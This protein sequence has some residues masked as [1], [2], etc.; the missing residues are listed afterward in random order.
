M[1]AASEAFKFV[2]AP[3]DAILAQHVHVRVVTLYRASVVSRAWAALFGCPAAMARAVDSEAREVGWQPPPGFVAALREGAVR[4]AHELSRLG[5]R[6]R[7]LVTQA[8][9]EE[10]VWAAVRASSPESVP[11]RSLTT[12]VVVNESGLDCWVHGIEEGADGRGCIRWRE[13][14]MV[15][16]AN[17]SL[18]D[19]SRPRLLETVDAAGRPHV[20]LLVRVS[21]LSHAFAL[22]ASEGAAPFA[23]YQQR[24]AFLEMR[25][26]H[27]RQI[28]VHAL[29]ILEGLEIE[30]LVCVQRLPV[31]EDDP[32]RL[33]HF[34]AV[35]CVD[36]RPRNSVVEPGT[37]PT[38][39]GSY[40]RRFRSAPAPAKTYGFLADEFAGLSLPQ[41][42]A[43]WP[44]QARTIVNHVLG[45][46]DTSYSHS[47][48]C[49]IDLTHL[50]ARVEGQ[51][52]YEEIWFHQDNL[53]A[54]GRLHGQRRGP[55]LDA[56]AACQQPSPA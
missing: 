22:C 25:T 31:S 20:G 36:N 17:R 15:A 27:W 7:L 10:N 21:T 33:P 50:A 47:P 53:F 45:R 8:G 32:N 19:D 52:L 34:Q 41:S 56:D 11:T 3:F 2:E 28:H 1:A 5:R 30:E 24:R 23:V 26:R 4:R 9:G 12:F 44:P 42:V 54:D 13:G 18:L 14:D 35:S 39:D 16:A 49:P 46:D 51:H 37:I 38:R 55:P 6:R 48:A 43:G 29:R 40:R